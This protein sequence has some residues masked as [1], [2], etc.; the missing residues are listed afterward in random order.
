MKQIGQ[1][2]DKKLWLSSLI[3]GVLVTALAGKLP[4]IH[5]TLMMVIF[6]L[7]SLFAVWTGWYL[8]HE[9]RGWQLL[10]FPFCFMVGAYFFTPRYSWYLVLV[11]LGIA[12][13]TWSLSS[14]KQD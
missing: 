14:E 3:A 12:Y 11:Y 5:K 10:V 6:L 8:R 13:L 2:I 4:F 1:K 9:K 7:L